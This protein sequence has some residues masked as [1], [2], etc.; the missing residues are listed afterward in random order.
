MGAIPGIKSVPWVVQ[1]STADCTT[2]KQPMNLTRC[3]AGIS[4]WSYCTAVLCGKQPRGAI[5]P[6]PHHQQVP[7]CMTS[8]IDQMSVDTHRYPPWRA[9]AASCQ[10]SSSHSGCPCLRPAQSASAAG[11]P[12]GFAHPAA[13]SASCTAEIPASSA[14]A[15]MAELARTASHTALR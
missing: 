2:R 15:G 13:A 8:V 5:R 11:R 1:C 7:H 3:E 12:P 4:Q 14:L 9:A 10:R 6:A